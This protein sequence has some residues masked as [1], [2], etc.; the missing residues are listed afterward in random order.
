MEVHIGELDEKF[1]QQQEQKFKLTQ[2]LA[3][4]NLSP[5]K[6]RNLQSQLKLLNKSIAG[7]VGKLRN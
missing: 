1:L 3:D 5:E 7:V 4:P 2:K 6:K